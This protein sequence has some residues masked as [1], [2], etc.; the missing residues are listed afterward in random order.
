MEIE[1]KGIVHNV[2]NDAP[3]VGAIIIAPYCKKNCEGCQ[4]IHLKEVDIKQ[5]NVKKIIEDVKKNI[6]NEGIILAGLEW[7]YTPISMRMLI[8]EALKEELKVMLYTFLDEETFKREYPDL[9]KKDIWIKFGEYRENERSDNY[10]SKGIKLATTNQY[11]KK[12][13]DEI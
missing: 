12:L 9:C 13:P 4:N 6:F 2:M 11:I 8:E 10:Y 1:Y 5:D 3:F 7:T